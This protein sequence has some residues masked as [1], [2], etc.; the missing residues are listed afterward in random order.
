MSLYPISH[1]PVCTLQ[2]LMSLQPST[3]QQQQQA[4]AQQQ[5]LSD[6]LA[7]Y[8]S[9]PLSVLA[10]SSLRSPWPQSSSV[11]LNLLQQHLQPQAAAAAAVAAQQQQ[12]QHQLQLQHSAQSVQS[13]P[14]YSSA[15]I[16][17]FTVFRSLSPRPPAFSLAH[18]TGLRRWVHLGPGTTWVLGLCTWVHRPLCFSTRVL[19]STGSCMKHP[20]PYESCVRTPQPAEQLLQG[21]S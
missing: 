15:S 2:S 3:Q 17:S 11:N 21:I 12:I 1:V 8:N 20:G 9:A 13:V 7:S 18:S 6:M 5:Q 10:F 19:T 4:A 16:P 14:Q